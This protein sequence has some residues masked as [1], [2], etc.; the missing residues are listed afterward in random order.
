[1]T[2]KSIKILNGKQRVNENN[3]EKGIK[4][5]KDNRVK[6]KEKEVGSCC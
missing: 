3:T 2:R 5:G 4:G 6:C 1:M